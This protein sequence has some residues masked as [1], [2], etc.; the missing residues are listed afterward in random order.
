MKSNREVAEEVLKGLWGNGK[1]RAL[2]L[3]AAG[4]DYNEIQKIVN[5]IVNGKEPEPESELLVVNVDL[6]KYK[7][8]ALYIEG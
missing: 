1:D 2:R 7:G 8:V 5:D 4:Y 6:K 3:E